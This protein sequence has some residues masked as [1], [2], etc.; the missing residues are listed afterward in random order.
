[1]W[2][3]MAL[4]R[5]L[6]VPGQVLQVQIGAAGQPGLAR[7]ADD[8]LRAVAERL[9]HFQTDDRMGLGGIGPDDEE[10]LRHS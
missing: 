5:K 3:I 8:Q 9:L 6:S 7:V 1:M 10:R 2:F 4:T